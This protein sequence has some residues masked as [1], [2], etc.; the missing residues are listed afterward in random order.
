MTSSPDRGLPPNRQQVDLGWGMPRVPRALGGKMGW[1]V[2]GED[3]GTRTGRRHQVAR[4][5][6][7]GRQSGAAG[8]TGA[9]DPRRTRAGSPRDPV[10][11][12]KAVRE[13]WQ[14]RAGWTGS[15]SQ[16][17]WCPASDRASP[18]SRRRLGHRGVCAREHSL[19]KQCWGQMTGH[20]AG[21][22]VRRLTVH[23]TAEGGLAQPGA[24]RNGRIL[25]T[26]RQAA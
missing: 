18:Q 17:P 9:K 3:A 21:T 1:L 2:A 13:E 8:G 16:E 14:E 25:G 7:R 24:V 26:S 20:Q 23:G 19:W 12:C 5:D 11:G 15:G 4:V 10:A 6:G 22:P